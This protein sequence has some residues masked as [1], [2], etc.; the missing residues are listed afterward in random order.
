MTL[1]S[2]T[3]MAKINWLILHEAPFLTFRHCLI[4]YRGGPLNLI[5]ELKSFPMMVQVGKRPP[6]VQ[7]FSGRTLRF[8]NC[9]FD[10]AFSS[11]PP[12]EGQ[13][14]TSQLLAQSAT[15]AEVGVGAG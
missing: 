1:D 2:T 11:P 7:T 10:F 9:R 4:V 5:V 14:F 15:S 6:T 12:Q 13:H 3:D 8:E